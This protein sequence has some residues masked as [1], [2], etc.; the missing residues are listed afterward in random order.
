[1]KLRLGGQAENVRPQFFACW[2]SCVRMRERIMGGGQV[3]PHHLPLPKRE[4]MCCNLTER[5]PFP[6]EL[7]IDS[8]HAD[9][10]CAFAL[11]LWD[12][13]NF[14]GAEHHFRLALEVRGPLKKDTQWGHDWIDGARQANPAHVPNLFH[15]GMMLEGLGRISVAE[16]MCARPSWL[17]SRESIMEPTALLGS[18]RRQDPAKAGAEPAPRPAAGIGACWL[19]T[20]GTRIAIAATGRQEAPRAAAQRPRSRPLALRGRTLERR[21]PACRLRASHQRARARPP[22]RDHPAPG[23]C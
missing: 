15:Y 19:W 10:F 16:M 2:R 1:M 9:S 17:H 7:V 18:S 3:V 20:S 11:L 5:A 8:T 14:A 6:Q 4:K 13:R 12:G 22:D 23:S 21:R